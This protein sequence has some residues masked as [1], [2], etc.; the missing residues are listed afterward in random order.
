[1]FTNGRSEQEKRR[2][3][4]VFVQSKKRGGMPH[5]NIKFSFLSF[6]TVFLLYAFEFLSACK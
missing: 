6:I 2:E 4:K 1:M 3:K 5:R